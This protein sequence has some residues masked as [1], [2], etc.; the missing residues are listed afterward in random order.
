MI[1][2]NGDA[3]M[4]TKRRLSSYALARRLQYLALQISAGKP[5]RMGS[6]SV[7]IPANAVIEEE[8]ETTSGETEILT[9]LPGHLEGFNEPPNKFRPKWSPATASLFIVSPFAGRNTCLSSFLR[10]R[11]WRNEWHGCMSCQGSCRAGIDNER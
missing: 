7:R 5:I 1:I 8:I 10:T 4:K 11:L 2:G 3:D 9:A 6:A